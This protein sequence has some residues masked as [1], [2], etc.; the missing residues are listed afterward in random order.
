MSGIR[1]FFS[2]L[3]QKASPKRADPDGAAKV[4]AIWRDI[5]NNTLQ[6]APD[7][8]A[9]IHKLILSLVKVIGGALKSNYVA[10]VA[11]ALM[12]HQIPKR[13]VEFAQA[14]VPHNLIN[15]VIAFF[16]YF[17]TP[18]FC[19]LL[20][21]PFIIEPMNILIENNQAADVGVYQR[22]IETLLHHVTEVPEH[23]KLFFV[24]ET[25]SPLVHQFSQLIVTRYGEMGDVLLQLLVT[26]KSIDGMLRYIIT[27]SPLISTLI[28]LIMD[29][30]R[31]KNSDPTLLRFL[32]FV[33]LAIEHG[34]DEFV[35]AFEAVF[36]ESIVKPM[37][38]QAPKVDALKNSVYLLSLFSCER[39][40]GNIVEFVVENLQDDLKSDDEDVLFL[41]IRL[42][43]LM[44]EKF[45][46]KL[47]LAPETVKISLDF[48]GMIASEWFVRSEINEELA[49]ARAQVSMSLSDIPKETP[50][51]DLTMLLPVLL[52]KLSS[53]VSNSLKVNVALCDL[54]A[55]IAALWGSEATYFALSE[56]CEDGLYKTLSQV[57]VVVERRVGHKPGT[58]QE[59]EGAYQRFGSEIESEEQTLLANVVILLEFLKELHAIAQSKNLLNQRN[60]LIIE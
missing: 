52:E 8:L 47:P 34:P 1:D 33:N 29:S 38:L 6:N 46:V 20:P 56:Q 50:I 21:Q 42:I 10:P 45:E 12:R 37:V 11:D 43:A 14:D 27:F 32:E 39:L 17:A 28:D 18:P 35:V 9:R 31:Q 55:S 59:I 25:S 41:T 19:T 16:T 49:K 4:E 54:F 26:A 48:M 3:S 22:L 23:L 24:S 15:E 51:F 58:V 53:F 13:L 7:A 36:D 40:I 60:S 5:C 2:K 30:V 57:C 44:T